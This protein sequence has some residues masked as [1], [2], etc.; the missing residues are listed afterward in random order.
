MRNIFRH[1]TRYSRKNRKEVKEC[2]RDRHSGISWRKQWISRECHIYRVVDDFFITVMR[3][4]HGIIR[5]RER[6]TQFLIASEIPWESNSYIQYI[7][8]VYVYYI[9]VYMRVARYVCLKK[10]SRGLNA[11]NTMYR[12]YIT[13]LMRQRFPRLLRMTFTATSWFVCKIFPLSHVDTG[14]CMYY[15]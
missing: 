14:L 12:C 13:R 1:V 11:E 5:D 9:Y 6:E 4:N 10:L 15:V 8:Y 7:Y 3:L 2:N